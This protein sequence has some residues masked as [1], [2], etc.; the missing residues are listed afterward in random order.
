MSVPVIL[1]IGSGKGGVG[2]TTT[3]A[4]LG[5]TLTRRGFSVGFID[6]D[7]GGANLHLFLGSDNLQKGLGTLLTEKDTPLSDVMN[8]LSFSND[9]WFVPAGAHSGD[10]ANIGFSQKQKLIRRF[11]ESQADYVF[12]DLGAGSHS[13]VTDFFAS[14]P[15]NILL[16]DGSPPSVE[17]AYIFLKNSVVRGLLRFFPGRQDIKKFIAESLST[18]GVRSVTSIEEMIVTLQ[19]SFSVDTDA[20]KSWLYSRR[21]YLVINMLTNSIDE[22]RAN[23][24]TNIVRK[25]L[26]LNCVYIGYV[27][28]SSFFKNAWNRGGSRHSAPSFLAEKPEKV[29]H[30][31]DTIAHNLITL[32]RGTSQ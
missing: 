20:L 18:G 22:Q 1:C 4:H 8:P 25:Y 11:R 27:A 28:Y 10:F 32:T 5:Y 12:I 14:F 29:S 13:H 21:I 19:H 6:A 24:L 23:K 15:H 9:S 31:F 30:C 3:I 26:A 2:K 16:I 17:N 7:V